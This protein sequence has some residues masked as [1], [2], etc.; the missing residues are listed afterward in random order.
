MISRVNIVHIARRGFSI[1]TM[2]VMACAVCV[3]GFI[4]AQRVWHWM[5][6]SPVFIVRSIEVHG[7]QRIAP[8]EIRRLSQL[9]EGMRIVDVKPSLTAKAIMGN[10]W[11][12]PCAHY[13]AVAK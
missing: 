3:G 1:V 6:T 9:H 8:Q 5:G 2:G 12:R 10:C 7:A 11:I 13:A 4:A